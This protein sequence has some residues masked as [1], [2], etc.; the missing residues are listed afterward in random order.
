MKIKELIKIF[1]EEDEDLEEKI[2][3]I[4]KW[5][6]IQEEENNAL[7]S[8]FISQAVGA[9]VLQRTGKLKESKEYTAM[10]IYRDLK[11]KIERRN[12]SSI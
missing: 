7:G 6:T 4:K 1:N 2:G 11:R 10:W 5:G 12:E 3:E 9:E 8:C